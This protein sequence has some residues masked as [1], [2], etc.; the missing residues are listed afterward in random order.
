MK[1]YHGKNAFTCI[2]K[3]PNHNDAKKYSTDALPH[4]P[5]SCLMSLVKWNDMPYRPYNSYN[6]GG[7]L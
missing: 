5:T 4:N 6:N 1:E 3:Y 7:K 2:V